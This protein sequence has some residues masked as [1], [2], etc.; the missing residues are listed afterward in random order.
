MPLQPVVHYQHHNTSGASVA[1]KLHQR[2]RTLVH[3]CTGV[4]HHGVLVYWCTTPAQHRTAVLE[5]YV[6]GGTIVAAF[7]PPSFNQESG[8]SYCSTAVLSYCSTVVPLYWC[9]V[10]VY[11]T[12]VLYCRGGGHT[13]SCN[14]ECRRPSGGGAVLLAMVDWWCTT[15]TTRS[16]TTAISSAST[17]H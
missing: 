15:S 16:T 8:C 13:L 3:W 17:S 10:L 2:T 1:G 5:V 7:T 12:A 6:T 11:C 4:L 14:L 9:I